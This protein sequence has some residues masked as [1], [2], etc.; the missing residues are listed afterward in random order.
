MMA[1]MMPVAVTPPVSAPAQPKKR[2]AA[3]RR[4]LSKTSH[5]DD[6]TFH[7]MGNPPPAARRIRRRN[8]RY[9]EYP[10]YNSGIACRT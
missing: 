4:T 8:D 1:R 7:T 2:P 9:R 3:C 6:W 5:P 10:P